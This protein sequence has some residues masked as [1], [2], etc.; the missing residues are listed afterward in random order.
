MFGKHSIHIK[1]LLMVGV[2]EVQS[3][4]TEIK[5]FDDLHEAVQ[6]FGRKV[7]IYRGVTSLDHKLIPQVGRLNLRGSGVRESKEK[8]I[9][10]LFKEQSIPVLDFT[11]DN[12][13]EWLAVAQHHGLPTRLL[14]WTRNP[15]VAAYFAVEKE[16]DD[17]SV[18]YAFHSNKFFSVDK[19]PDPFKID[20]IGRF[21]PRHITRRITAQGGLFTVHPNPEEPFESERISRLIIR[22]KFRRQLKKTLN[23]YGIHRAMLFPDLDGIA[24]HI[25]WMRTNEH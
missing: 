4:D 10:R 20:D 6:S 9:L 22:K 12:D 5:K 8:M 13:W 11:P 7:V 19:H 25:R 18:I 17:D 24:A 21:I 23:K 1:I 2:F 14:D 15:L 16:H 3:L